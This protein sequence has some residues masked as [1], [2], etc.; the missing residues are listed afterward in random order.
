MTEQQTVKTFT[1]KIVD[2]FFELKQLLDKIPKAAT[3][4]YLENEGYVIDLD[5]GLIEEVLEKEGLAV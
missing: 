4:F 3:I 2:R 1:D 5:L